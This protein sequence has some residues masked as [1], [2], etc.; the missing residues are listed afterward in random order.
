MQEAMLQ[1]ES[2]GISDFGIYNLV[3]AV[4]GKLIN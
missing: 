2:L 4:V 1:L 3:Q